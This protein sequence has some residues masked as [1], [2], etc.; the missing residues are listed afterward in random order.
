MGLTYICIE[1]ESEGE[2]VCAALNEAGVNCNVSL[3]HELHGQYF[4]DISNIFDL[5]LDF[6]IKTPSYFK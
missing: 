1:T 3:F 4:T 5:F 6:F 2:A